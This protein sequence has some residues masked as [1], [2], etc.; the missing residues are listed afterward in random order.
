MTV[1]SKRKKSVRS[2]V[3]YDGVVAS[4][5]FCEVVRSP[6]RN[7]ARVGGRTPSAF[8]TTGHLRRW[9]FLVCPI[10]VLQGDAVVRCYNLAGLLMSRASASGVALLLLL[11]SLCCAAE[12]SA[13]TER[14]F[15]ATVRLET[16]FLNK[17]HAVTGHGTGFFFRLPNSN[18]TLIVTNKRVLREAGLELT[19]VE[20]VLHEADDNGSVATTGTKRFRWTPPKDNAHRDRIIWHEKEYVD[21]AAIPFR[22]WSLQEKG[23][24]S[25]QVF[26]HWIP[27]SLILTD[28]EL[29]DMVNGIAPVFMFGYPLNLWDSRNNLPI[30]RMGHTASLAHI[31]YSPHLTH[32]ICDCVPP[33]GA[34]QGLL[35]IACFQGSSGSPVFLIDSGPH[36]DRETGHLNLGNVRTIFLGIVWGYAPNRLRDTVRNIPTTGTFLEEDLHIGFYWKAR[37]LLELLPQPSVK[38]TTPSLEKDALSKEKNTVA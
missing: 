6:L 21:V 22:T 12:Y 33:V 34:A 35:D 38:K 37:E 30:A 25:R 5:N 4:R 20:C 17:T 32:P 7:R 24:E 29:F 3:L 28:D 14:L 23:N 19:Q 9:G 36:L 11:L 8:P 10:L 15:Y 1:A 2:E 13:I 18:T 16:R 26:F 27:H 31:N